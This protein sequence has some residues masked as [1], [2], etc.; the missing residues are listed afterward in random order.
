MALQIILRGVCGLLALAAL[1]SSA[2]LM[3]RAKGQNV[4][5]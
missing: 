2:A 5:S 1:P 4:R 3:D